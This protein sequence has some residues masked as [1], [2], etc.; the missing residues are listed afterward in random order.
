MEVCCAMAELQMLIQLIQIRS[1]IQ[2]S[3]TIDFGIKTTK[4][5]DGKPFLEFMW[6]RILR[7]RNYLSCLS[8]MMNCENWI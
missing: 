6:S 8:C 1:Q 2:C 7:S 3:G 4:D 5:E